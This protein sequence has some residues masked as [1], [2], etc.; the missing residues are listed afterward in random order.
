V[1]VSVFLPQYDE[2]EKNE[3]EM[4]SVTLV[5]ANQRAGFNEYYWLGFP[6]D[7]L[8]IG[9]VNGNGADLGEFNETRKSQV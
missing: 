2:E 4:D 3:A 9:F 1:Q 6:P 8:R 7:D 5:Q